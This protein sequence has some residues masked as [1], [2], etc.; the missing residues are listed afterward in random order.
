MALRVTQAVPLRACLAGTSAV[1]L[2]LHPRGLGATL[3]DGHRCRATRETAC[4][5]IVGV[6]EGGFMFRNVKRAARAVPRPFWRRGRAAEL[7]G[8]M[9]AAK[10]PSA[11]RATAGQAG[12][13]AGTGSRLGAQ[14]LPR[15]ST[16]LALC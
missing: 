13:V 6:L 8:G 15:S 5:S 9:N 4:T 12:G 2:A 7:P 10:S 14:V 1:L 11:P 16:P 3:A